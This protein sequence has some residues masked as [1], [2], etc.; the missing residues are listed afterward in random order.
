MKKVLALLVPIFILV[1][2]G[3]CH[4]VEEEYVEGPLRYEFSEGQYIV[5]GCDSEAEEVVIPSEV[6]GIRVGDIKQD[7][8]AAAAKL[9]KIT[10][11]KSISEIDKDTFSSSDE[12]AVI[13]VDAEN[14]T[15]CDADG[16]LY[17]K[18][19]TKLVLCPKGKEVTSFTIPETVTEISYGAF[20]G[21]KLER[22]DIPDSVTKIGIHAFSECRA[23][24]SIT[25]PDRVLIRYDAFDNTKYYN[26]EKNWTDGVLYIGNI[27]LAAKRD[28]TECT[29]REGTVNIAGLAFYTAFSLTK[30]TIPESVEIIQNSAFRNCIS[31]ASVTIPK[32]V[33]EIQDNAF[34]YCTSLAEINIEGDGPISIGR[35]VLGSTAY[36]ENPDNWEGDELYMLYIKNVLV[37]VKKEAKGVIYVKEGTQSIASMAFRDCLNIDAIVIPE[38]VEYIGDIYFS[39]TKTTDIYYAKSK[40]DWEK[41][42]GDGCIISDVTIYFN[43]KGPERPPEISLIFNGEHLETD[44]SP[45]IKNGR[46]MVPMRAIFEALGASVTWD[47]DANCAYAKKGD[48]EIKVTI[49]E[50]ILYKDGW[51][52]ALDSAPMI[53]SGRTMVP[54]RAVSEAFGADVSWDNELRCVIIELGE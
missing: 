11:G 23:L 35:D 9:K 53:I 34:L 16:V 52:I 2:C 13:M 33:K 28:I 17:T 42:V 30:V 19:M 24:E 50:Y 45:M 6:N 32:S 14:D 54:V 26:D 38:S 46:T 31:L 27:L 49:G 1:F 5:A 22:I 39:G 8:F 15:Y 41:A 40:S 20:Y 10:I 4:A 36:V 12:L 7:A 21:C 18:D 47:G 3:V 51:G 29:I 37:G 43:N 25:L 44:V 48:T